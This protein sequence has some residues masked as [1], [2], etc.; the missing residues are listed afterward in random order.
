MKNRLLSI[1]KVVLF[2]LFLG[3]AMICVNGTTMFGKDGSSL[4]PH[5]EFFLF[6]GASI[7]SFLA[8]LFVVAKPKKIYKPNLIILCGFSLVFLIGFFTLLTFEKEKVFTYNTLLEIEPEVFEFSGPEVSVSYVIEPIYRLTFI[9]QWFLLVL[10]TY[11]IFDIVP[12]VFDRNEL[13][14][15]FC[16]GIFTIATF[17]CIYSYITEA[18]SYR[19]FIIKGIPE[20][21]IT[22]YNTFSIFSVANKNSYGFMLFLAIICTLIMH[23]LK[24]K[25]WWFAATG[26]FY[27]NLIFNWNKSALIFGALIILAYL[28]FRFFY[29]Y[30]DNKKRNLITLSVIGGLSLCGVI[31]LLVLELATHKIFDIIFS[32]G[33]AYGRSTLM[34]RSWIY[35][36]DMIIFNDNSPLFGTGF[37]LFA[38]ILLAVNGADIADTANR[39]I[40][41]AHNG[42]FEMIGN[43]GL[44]LLAAFLLLTAYLIY[45]SIIHFKEEKMVSFFTMLLVT[46]M[47]MYMM[48]ESGT[49]IFSQT[50]DYSIL[51]III[52][53]PILNVHHN[54]KAEAQKA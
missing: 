41:S 18:A 51:S 36:K 28:I 53:V 17:F 21:N 2:A 34:T 15:Y 8:F 23:S 25:W 4:M 12:K 37:K 27:L 20:G 11:S 35:H 5:W 29:T 33:H 31:S 40:G 22:P 13:L 7:A 30:K 47:L 39:F 46:I 49:Y 16:F 45:L 9:C 32:S 19:D 38:H 26:Y 43:G 42:Y 14:T 50:L 52:C 54:H 3:I 48:L 24:P 6:F 44:I 10:V 1:S